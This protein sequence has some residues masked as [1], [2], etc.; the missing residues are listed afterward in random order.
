[1]HDHQVTCAFV[2]LLSLGQLAQADQQQP[3]LSKSRHLCHHFTCCAAVLWSTNIVEMNSAGGD[4]GT[5][6]DGAVSWEDR[7]TQ[8][9]CLERYRVASAEIIAVFHEVA[10]EA[11]VEKASIDEAYIDVTNIVDAHLQVCSPLLA[12]L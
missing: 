8:K 7:K 6:N 11:V 5:G 9:A 2:L 10:P 12:S 3:L 1:M 4:A